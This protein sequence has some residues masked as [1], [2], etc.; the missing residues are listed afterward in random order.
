MPA[1]GKSA[2]T[3]VD[4]DAFPGAVGILAGLGKMR[5]IE[6]DVVGDEEI[7]PAIAVVVDEAAARAPTLAR[8]VEAGLFRD[9]GERAVA[10]VAVENIVAPV[11]DEQIVE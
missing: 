5:Q 10:V 8:I 7:E 6:R 11:G 4:R 9:I 2:R 3:A 1:G